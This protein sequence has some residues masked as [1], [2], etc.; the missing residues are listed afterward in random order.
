MRCTNECFSLKMH[1]SKDHLVHIQSIAEVMWEVHS[2]FV[3]GAAVGENSCCCGWYK[4]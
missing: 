2:H 1:S 3:G 4:Y